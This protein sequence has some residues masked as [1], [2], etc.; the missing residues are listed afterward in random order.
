MALKYFKS[1]IATYVIALGFVAL[2]SCSSNKSSDNLV[3]NPDSLENTFT[4]PLFPDCGPDP[5]AVYHDGYYYYMHT[6]QDSLVVWRTS[7]LSKVK[8]S[9]HKTVWT[10]TD[11]RHSHHLW[12]PEIHNIDN[13]WYIY[14]AADDGNTDNHQI[15]VLENA[16][17]N[18]LEGEFTFKGRISTDSNNNWAIDASVFTH[19][20]QLYMVWSGWQTRRID[21]ETQCIYIAR[22]AN[23][24]TLDSERVLI[25]KPE[26]DWERKYIN[27]DGSAPDYIIYVNEGPQPLHDPSGKYIHI[28]YSASGCWTPYYSLGMLT[29]TSDADLLS[30]SSWKKADKPLFV[31]SE[32]NKV[33]GCG[34]NSFFVSPDSTEHY[35]LYHARD[36]QVDPPGKGDTRTPRMQRFDWVD[37]FPVFGKPIAT[38]IRLPKPSGTKKRN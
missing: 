31:Q 2:S 37:G 29:A 20:G 12:A 26:L 8:D 24:W 32:E 14:Y 19:Q 7:D 18:P 9:E 34:H 35:I 16:N 21:T 38:S 4:N 6:C 15:Y 1:I 5:W 33:Y 13:K 28:I 3:T 30:P 17:P 22:M 10:P 25:S 11:P 27:P 23:P 36:T